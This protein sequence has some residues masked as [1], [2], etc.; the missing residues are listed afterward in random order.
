MSAKNF[1]GAVVALEPQ[2]GDDPGHGLH[3]VATTRT[4]WPATTRPSSRRPGRS[5]NAADPPVLT[6]RAISETYPPGSTFKLVD[7]AA[8]LQ[9]GVHPGQP[10][11]GG[12]EH[13]ARRTPRRRWRTTTA[14]PCGTGATASLRDAL[15]RSCNTAFAQL[16]RPA[17]RGQASAQQAESFGIGRT[18]LQI[19]MTVQALLGRARSPTPPSTAAVGDRPA[20]RRADPAAERH[21]RRVDRERR[22]D[23]RAAPDQGDPEPAARRRGHDRA[24][25]D[26]PVDA[27]QRRVH[28]DRPHG[29]LGE[30]HAGRREDH[31]RADRVQDRHRRARHRPEEHAAARL[32]RGVRA[33]RGPEGRG[34]R[35]RGERR[36]P[37]DWRRP[38]ARSRRRSAARSSPRR[39]EA[40]SDPGRP[41][42]PGG[43]G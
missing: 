40:A 30:P 20:R 2:T 28:A 38:A 9:N 36:R 18:D 16:G 27:A 41:S 12:A 1:E 15:P 23:D 39:C 14:T 17:R 26:E 19:P 22:P 6:N 13:H 4:R 3:A 29:R 31:R 33:G 37:R 42:G 24:G 34:R 10:A 25:P 5:Y 11:H 43:T 35:D 21:D 8:A 32:V 7:T